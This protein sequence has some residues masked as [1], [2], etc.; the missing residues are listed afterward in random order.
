MTRK[1]SIYNLD[2]SITTLI[3]AGGSPKIVSISYPGNDTAI[4]TLG[5]GTITITG[6]IVK[7]P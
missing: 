4:D 3:G 1:I 7:T 6:A 2:A 5:T